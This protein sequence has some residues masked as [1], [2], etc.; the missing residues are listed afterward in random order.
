MR[1]QSAQAGQEEEDKTRDQDPSESVW[2]TEYHRPLGRGARQSGQLCFGFLL[3]C[4]T[5]RY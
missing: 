3:I 2:W 4:G 5:F 1:H